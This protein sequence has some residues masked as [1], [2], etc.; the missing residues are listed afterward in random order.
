M[1]DL[2]QNMRV[3]ALLQKACGR[4]L[5]VRFMLFFFLFSQGQAPAVLKILGFE[6][7]FPQREGRHRQLPAWRRKP[8]WRRE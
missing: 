3:R 4:S 1:Q 8:G 2:T 6:Q 5:R 7:A